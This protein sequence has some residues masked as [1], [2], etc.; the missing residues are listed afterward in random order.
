MQCCTS[1][2]VIFAYEQPK[3]KPMLSLSSYNLN[4]YIHSFN[5]NI[6]L[7]F[8]VKLFC[9]NK[10]DDMINTLYFHGHKVTYEANQKRVLENNIIILHPYMNISSVCFCTNTLRNI[11]YWN[12]VVHPR[13]VF[14]YIYSLLFNGFL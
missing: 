8:Q 2:N 4:T 7:L 3:G 14:P 13:F 5:K 11:R 1:K 10:Y 12:L 6:L 9:L